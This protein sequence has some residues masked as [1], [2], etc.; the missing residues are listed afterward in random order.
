MYFWARFDN[1]PCVFCKN[2]LISSRVPDF[3][4]NQVI[5]SPLI[6]FSIC[7]DTFYF[8]FW[9]EGII[10]VVLLLPAFPHSFYIIDCNTV[11]V[12]KI[13]YI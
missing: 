13:I 8:S 6:L 12:R 10:Y 2:E 5:L 7:L 9:S 4:P 3:T 1:L 11:R